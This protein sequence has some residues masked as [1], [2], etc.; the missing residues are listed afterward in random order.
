MSAIPTTEYAIV[1]PIMENR[2]ITRSRYKEHKRTVLKCI[3][4]SVSVS[5]R[6]II[7][8]RGGADWDVNLSD[9][10]NRDEE[11]YVNSVPNESDVEEESDGG[12]AESEPVAAVSKA[13]VKLIIK[14]ALNSHLI[15][16]SIELTASR[17][18]DVAS[19]KLSCFRQMR[20]RPPVELQTIRQGIITLEDHMTID[21]IL[22]DE[23]D[24]DDDDDDEEEEA[25]EVALILTLDMAPPVDPKFGIELGE[26]VK[27][28]TTEELIDAYAAN[29]AS[30]MAVSKQLAE[31][32]VSELDK[33]IEQTTE[34]YE[35]EEDSAPPP[36][37]LLESE[38]LWMRK[39]A[40]LV[41]KQLLSSMSEDTLKMLHKTDEE[42]ESSDALL[43]SSIR[44]SRR[45][46][47][48][49]NMKRVLQRN[50]NIVSLNRT[51]VPIYF[52]SCL[53]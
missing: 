5:E 34:E 32:A 44:R 33:V 35:G 53:L 39:Q 8:C 30:L 36:K 52:L 48:K 43:A 45:G 3:S 50:L 31:A 10:N 6:A 41:K 19:L 28:K 27:S 7:G 17:T 37:A 15:D 49:M 29:Q 4:S 42:E 21:E 18:R 2:W 47:A 14:T 12:G 13:P 51:I 46:G 11:G 1:C 20:G 23:D 24:D 25:D 22:G 38:T 40:S 16:Q 9:E 26:L